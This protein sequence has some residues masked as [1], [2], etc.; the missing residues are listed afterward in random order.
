MYFI[1]QVGQH[2]CAFTCL[3]ILLA[4]YHHDKN[5]LFIPG[6]EEA[7]NFKELKDIAAQYHM[8]TL[9]IK[10]NSVQELIGSKEFP[11]MITLEKSKGHRHSVIILSANRKY[12]RIFD[13][14][15]GKRKIPLDT[16]YEQW[17]LRAL[18][19]KK[20]VDHVRVECDFKPQDFIAKKDKITLPIWQLLSGISLLLGVYFIN[21]NS[22][23]F[24][25]II[26]FSLFFIFEI[27][28][29]KGLINA[30][31]RM[32]DNIFNYKI[33]V[34]PERLY[35]FYEVEE[36]YRYVALSIIPNFI[37]TVLIAVFMTV[38]LIM[39]S[40]LNAVYVLLALI[41]A[42]AHVYVYLPYHR[43]KSSD[44]AEQEALIKGVGN[45]FQFRAIVNNVHE[46][47]YQLGL[48]RNTFTYIEIAI[49]L[50]S[51][52]TIM[53]LSGVVS[54]I[55]VVFYLCISVYLKDNFIRLFEC[56]SQ[57]ENFDNQ[58]A[59]LLSYLDLSVCNNSIE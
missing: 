31:K 45:Q 26:L 48:F 16:L 18:I 23:F 50:M 11:F 17:D 52:V 21:A 46:A 43:R 27:F 39:N 20:E 13:P 8:G 36:K 47:A 29:R 22:Y 30:M 41:I 44:L 58:L 24:I 5:Y 2:D 32:D 19:I 6:K 53:S 15:T 42:I 7:Y 40:A 55:Y 56:S 51:A 10:I 33:K 59:K 12:V 3:K 28:F 38:L 25:P 14:E 9:G 54:V 34:A 57:S 4:N 37:Y 49:L 35:E 1:S